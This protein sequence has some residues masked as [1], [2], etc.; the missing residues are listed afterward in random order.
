MKR[1]ITHLIVAL[2]AVFAFS[3]APAA[4]QATRTWVSGVGDDANPCSRTAPCKTFQGAFPKT[5]TGGEINVLDPGGY[6]SLSIIKP[7]TLRADGALGS[8]LTVNTNGVT[9]NLPAGGRV[10]IQ[11][12]EL[13]GINQSGATGLAGIKIVSAATVLL[14]DSS[15]REFTSGIDVDTTGTVDLTV[16]N[17]RI[18]GNTQYGVSLSNVSGKGRAYVMHSLLANNALGS[19]H[20][21][22][23]SNTFVISGDDFTGRGSPSLVPENGGKFISFGDNAFSDVPATGYVVTPKN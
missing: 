20:A 22:G 9:V 18:I 5:A 14:V 12:I 2:A 11:G 21:N 1:L 10:V 7:I 13:E 16:E 17:S 19:L 15:I 3:A 23:S 4:A 6:G 8:I